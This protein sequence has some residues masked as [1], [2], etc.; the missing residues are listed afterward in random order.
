MTSALQHGHPVYDMIFV[1]LAQRYGCKL[2]TTDKKLRALLLRIDPALCVLETD[3][4]AKT[5]VRESPA[6]RRATPI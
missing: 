2:L 4:N 6:R 1:A 5:A 3:Q